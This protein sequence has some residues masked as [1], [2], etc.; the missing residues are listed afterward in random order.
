[1]ITIATA[2]KISAIIDKLEL[3]IS[4]PEGSQE[5]VGADLIMQVVSKAHKAEKE[6]L[7]LIANIKKCS[8][9]DA[10]NVD[11]LEFIKE[12]ADNDLMSFFTSQVRSKLQD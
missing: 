1:M 6:I 9:A 11:L 2:L 7:A 10:A 8:L 4:N 3:K 5:Q 12:F